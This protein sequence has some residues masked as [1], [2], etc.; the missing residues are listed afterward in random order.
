MNPTLASML[1]LHILIIL[2]YS[3]EYS[4]PWPVMHAYSIPGNGVKWFFK[5][6]RTWA[7]T[8]SQVKEIAEQN[9][10]NVGHYYY[11]LI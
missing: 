9:Q 7:K 4:G 5:A 6:V 11:H 8:I 2:L 3:D 10:H 1:I